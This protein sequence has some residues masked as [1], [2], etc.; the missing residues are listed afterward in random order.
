MVSSKNRILK[1]QVYK[2]FYPIS[3][4]LPF[5]AHAAGAGLSALLSSPFYAGM[6]SER[7]G[8]RG[9]TANRGAL[10]LALPPPRHHLDSAVF[11]ARSGGAQ[12]TG[13]AGAGAREA[14][15]S[16]VAGR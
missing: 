5:S 9:S 14:R 16:A 15:W 7:Q 1:T 8:S 11:G 12:K 6:G 4:S 3:P 2:A 10:P 13:R